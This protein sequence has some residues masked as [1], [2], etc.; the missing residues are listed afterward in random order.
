MLVLSFG[1]YS[2]LSRPLLSLLPDWRAKGLLRAKE[3]GRSIH[4]LKRGR[5]VGLTSWNSCEK[6]GAEPCHS[7]Y[8]PS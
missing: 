8:V 2:V 5:V 1:P 6:S 3:V 7:T 4:G